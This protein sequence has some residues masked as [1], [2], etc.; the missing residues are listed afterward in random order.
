[1]GAGEYAYYACTCGWDVATGWQLWY[2]DLHRP[3]GKPLGP[4]TMTLSKSTPPG[5]LPVT[6]QRSFA[7][8]TKVTLT[9]SAGSGG[10]TETTPC[11]CWSDGAETG[12]P[13]CCAGNSN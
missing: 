2:A 8:G 3:L 1:M 10:T 7:T 4:A 9:L 13:G 12:A 5:A 11:I 6:Y